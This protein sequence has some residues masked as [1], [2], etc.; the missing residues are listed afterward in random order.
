MRTHRRYAPLTAAFARGSASIVSAT[1]LAALRMEAVRSI[2]AG[3][4][5]LDATFF[6]GE[7]VAVV[8]GI[9]IDPAMLDEREESPLIWPHEI[10]VRIGHETVR[11]I[12]E[13]IVPWIESHAFNHC[14]N[15]ERIALYGSA[16]FAEMFS[17]AR[18]LAFCGAAPYAA[19]LS[20]LAP[21]WYALRFAQD[22]A[23]A[24]CDANA[25]SGAAVLAARAR[26]MRADLGSAG[27]NAL[28]SRWFG[29]DGFGAAAGG[30]YDVAIGADAEAAVRIDLNSLHGMRVEIATPLPVEILL[31]FETSE[32]AAVG[33]FAV[34]SAAKKTLRAAPAAEIPAVGGSGGRILLLLRENYER[35]PDADSDQALLLAARLRGEGFSVDV[36]AASQGR[37]VEYDLVHAFNAHA[38]AQFRESL[39]AARAA[40]KPVVV[41]PAFVDVAAEAAWGIEV[42]TALSRSDRDE[43]T[44]REHLSMLE[45]RR[46]ETS[47]GGRG[48][49]PHP[50]Y[51]AALRELLENADAILCASPAEASAV[52]AFAAADRIVQ[53][54]PNLRDMSA[55]ADIAP[56]VG[57][58]GFILCHAPL[59]ARANHVLL[60]RAAAAAGLPLVLTGP[61][62]DPAYA[63]SVRAYAG[64]QTI[65][66]P[67]P[68]VAIAAALYRSATVFADVSWHR[69]GPGRLSQAA[70]CGCALVI[71]HDD[72]VEPRPGAVW[73]VDAASERAISVALTDAWT[74]AREN[75]APLADFA[76]EVAAAHAGGDPLRAV[77]GAYAKASS[78]PRVGA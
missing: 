59:E 20:R 36:R 23:I 29:V 15:D 25:G 22:A 40:G 19:V 33:S 2:L 43:R 38:A 17:Q 13:A 71:S 49:E 77:A 11:A 32:S 18:K 63:R 66:L 45:K 58:G 3:F 8:P 75:P 68:D 1:N 4:G 46:I 14:V 7:R 26:R 69:Y 76:R 74:H 42:T 52:A 56:L 9:E 37:P 27:A 50:G 35:A 72:A 34:Q 57:T 54:P 70:A 24:I 61:T 16:E 47:A 55:A 5:L 65:F 48:C 44:F 6:D 64:E 53:A 21:Y 78:R 31:S 51:T 73:H 67:E 28:A 12:E 39:A 30:A 60:V 10:A 62:T 41:T